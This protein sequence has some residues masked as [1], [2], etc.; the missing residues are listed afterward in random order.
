MTDRD[1]ELIDALGAEVRQE[2]AAVVATTAAVTADRTT[3]RWLPYIMVSVALVAALVSAATTLLV[4]ELSTRVSQAEASVSELRRLADEA[5]AA[6]EAAN[7]ELQRRG[8]QPVPIPTPGGAQ[9]TEVLVAAATARVLASLPDASPT[10]DELAAAIVG[11][12]RTN[13]ALV[14][15]SPQQIGAQVAGYFAANPPPS[16]PPGEPGEQ[17]APGQQGVQGV[18]GPRGEDGRPPTAEEIRA[19]ISDLVASDPGV[20]CPR[21]GSF[22]QLR[23]QLADG[24]TADTWTCVVQIDPPST[25]PTTSSVPPLLPPLGR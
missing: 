11:V 8:Q 14:A 2:T 4:A 1:D 19:A 17:G 10:A 18:P 9:D 3:K 21:G 22:S 16:G 24:A 13:P 6:G 23:V 15:P 12:V 20:L 7:A 25:S 5:A